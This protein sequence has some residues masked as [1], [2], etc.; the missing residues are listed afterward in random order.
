MTRLR[1]AIAATHCSLFQGGEA[2]LSYH[3]FR[4]LRGRGVDVH[5]VAHGRCGDELRSAFPRDAERI[6]LVEDDG[7]DRLAWRLARPLPE[8]LGLATVGA[9]TFVRTQLRQRELLRDLVR[10]RGVNVIHQPMPVSPSQ[11][12]LL[13]GLGAPVVIG[14]MN[15]AMN[16]PRAF[17][18]R[19]P[20]IDRVARWTARALAGPLNALLPGKH[21]A[22]A[23]LVANARTAA[24]LP[25]EPVHVVELPENGI[26][27]ELWRP[28]R[29][30][31]DDSI[32][33]FVVS[34]RLVRWKGIDL[35]LEAW[36]R[37]NG[38]MRATLDVLG[39][40]HER[41][42]LEALAE[43]LGLLEDGSVRFH[44][45]LPQVACAARLAI[46]DALVLPSLLECG[47]A[48]VLEGMASGL[49]VIATAWGGPCDYIDESCGIL[50]EPTSREGLV[51]G[52]AAAMHR[53]HDDPALRQ[54]LGAAGRERARAGYDW[55]RKVDR[56]LEVYR[57]VVDTRAAA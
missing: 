5:L 40:G 37:A 57:D 31:P 44:G 48:V 24:A 17:R 36:A 4:V 21:E 18:E 52:L 56:L 11:P 29:M 33:R 2:A 41:A 42:A 13:Y 12:S 23:L 46:A 32:V 14:P 43:R 25:G 50:V 7:Y 47:G 6:H 1:V 28:A 34:G 55:E 22:A 30:R 53:L 51:S 10:D 16:H 20:A 15:G 39:D 54:R 49:P 27:A 38:S 19:E 35:L 45:W 3:C 8:R 26:D 9:V